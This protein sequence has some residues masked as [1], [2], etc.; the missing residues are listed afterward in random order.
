MD[1]AYSARVRVGILL[2]VFFSL[3][4]SYQLFVQWVQFDL[5]FVGGDDITLNEKRFDEIK[6]SLPSHGVVGYWPNGAPTTFDQLMFGNAADL[7]NWFLTQYALAPVIVSPTLG[8][9]L[10]ISNSRG[11]PG[12]GLPGGKRI[13]KDTVDGRKVLDFGNGVKLIKRELE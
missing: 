11:T 10:I 6:E 9:S 13:I 12:L 7:Q 2:I 1:F 5:S 3:L 4:S 8:H